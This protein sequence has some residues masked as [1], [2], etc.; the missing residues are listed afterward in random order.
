MW[1]GQPRPAT[2]IPQ[3]S[4]YGAIGHRQWVKRNPLVIW[5]I[6][7]MQKEPKCRAYS[8]YRFHSSLSLLPVPRTE[9]QS[10]LRMSCSYRSRSSSNVPL[11]SAREARMRYK[12]RL[13]VLWGVLTYICILVG[14]P[15]PSRSSNPS[16]GS[17]IG[18]KPSWWVGIGLWGLPESSPT[19][20]LPF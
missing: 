13:L 6:D 3:F 16:S 8:Q 5:G 2:G 11:T 20:E 7:D 17:I 10:L 18:S 9:R 15:V 4:I 19:M 1:H 14:F 12:D